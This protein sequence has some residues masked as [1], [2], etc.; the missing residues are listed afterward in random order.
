MRVALE[1]FGVPEQRKVVENRVVLG[2]RHVV[3]QPRAGQWHVD[4]VNQVVVL[5]DHAVVHVGRLLAVVEEQQLT[6]ARVDLRVRRHAPVE[7]KR[8]VEAFLAQRVA[9]VRVEP[10]QIAALVEAGERRPAVHD[11]VGARRV[12]HQSACAPA[13]VTFGHPNRL[14]QA[15]PQRPA[16][17][18]FRQESVGADEPVAVERFSVA[19]SDDVQHAVAVEGVI[20]LERGVQRVLGVAQIDAVEIPRNLT[21]D[22]RQVVGVP[23]GGLRS[24]RARPV[25]VVIV[26]GQGG[27]EFADDLHIHDRDRTT[28]KRVTRGIEES[29]W[30][31]GPA[32]S[33]S[34]P[35]RPQ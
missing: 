20:R 1:Q 8:A 23:L 31:G 28:T 9:G 17:L 29:R 21:L 35:T 16:G 3:R 14:G 15:G 27:Q 25:R 12:L 33:R 5:V 32:G 22:D 2:E 19:E 6:G 24:P 7:R 26:V 34:E 4:V 30:E 13:V 11:H 18:V 10:I